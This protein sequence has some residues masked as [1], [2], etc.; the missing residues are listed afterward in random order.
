MPVVTLI[1]LVAAAA[2]GLLLF[3]L[4]ASRRGEEPR[5]FLLEAEPTRESFA[6]GP[7]LAD[8]EDDR[9]AALASVV[10]VTATVVAGALVLAGLAWL[11]G[12]YVN[13]R[14]LEYVQVP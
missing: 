9:P 4:A 7:L 2:A 11:I 12:S 5:P 8:E 13:Q 1:A 3:R 6:F 10:R 14:L